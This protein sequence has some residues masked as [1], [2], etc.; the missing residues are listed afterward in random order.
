MHALTFVCRNRDR[1]LEWNLSGFISLVRHVTF[2]LSPLPWQ[3]N[4]KAEFEPKSKELRLY[5][6]RFDALVNL[7]V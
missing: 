5:K 1:F 6:V 2:F 3:E 4:K 7:C